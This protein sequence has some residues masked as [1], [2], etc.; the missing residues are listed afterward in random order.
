MKI[1][2][3]LALVSISSAQL[4][5]LEIPYILDSATTP[6]VRYIDY[7]NTAIKNAVN[8][9]TTVV[10][11]IVLFDSLSV[12]NIAGSV[13]SDSIHNGTLHDSLLIKVSIAPWDSAFNDSDGYDKGYPVY[14]SDGQY[15]VSATDNNTNVCP[16]EPGGPWVN[17]GRFEDLIQALFGALIQ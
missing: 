3:V 12:A 13:V 7:N 17:V 2:A 8:S 6:Q 14:C 11:N 16:N 4:A 10:N 9:I 15:Y 5:P 1:F